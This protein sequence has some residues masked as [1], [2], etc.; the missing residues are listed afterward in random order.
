M[1]FGL[2]LGFNCSEELGG[3]HLRRALEHSL[4]HACDRPADLNLAAVSDYG[5]VVLPRKIEVTGAFQETRLTFSVDYHSKVIRR[6]EI[7]KSDIPGEKPFYRADARPECCG[8]RILP[9]LLE[10]L[11]TRYAALQHRR[12]D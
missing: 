4:A 2:R 10:P 12:V 7:F 1:G 8:I 3:H 9:G 5:Y 11:A 6:S